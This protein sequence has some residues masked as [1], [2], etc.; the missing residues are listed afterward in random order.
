MTASETASI[1]LT[2]NKQA[3]ETATSKDG[4]IDQ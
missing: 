4:I 2:D 1:L 3:A